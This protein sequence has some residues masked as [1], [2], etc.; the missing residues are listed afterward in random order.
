MVE[1][2]AE[3]VDPGTQLGALSVDP[4][5]QAIDPPVRFADRPSKL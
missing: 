5:A 3:G 2:L 1:A 4:L